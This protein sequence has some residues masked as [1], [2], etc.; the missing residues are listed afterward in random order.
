MNPKTKFPSHRII[1]D[2]IKAI[3]VE[4]DHDKRRR[5]I[6]NADRWLR[7]ELA[8]AK[9]AEFGALQELARAIQVQQERIYE[10]SRDILGIKD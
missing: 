10:E 8:V 9:Q 5:L 6:A 3:E 2:A 7:S 1:A 4:P